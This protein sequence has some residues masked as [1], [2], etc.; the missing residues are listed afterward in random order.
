MLHQTNKSRIERCTI[1]A[2][3]LSLVAMSA[4]SFAAMSAF[5]PQ[6]KAGT[7][8]IRY[9]GTN[10]TGE[11]ISWRTTRNRTSPSNDTPETREGKT[12][13]Y[14]P[15]GS[16]APSGA[17]MRG[18][19]QQID[20]Y[21]KATYSGGYPPQ[22]TY[23]AGNGTVFAKANL[24]RRFEWRPYYSGE[25][26]PEYLTVRFN[27]SGAIY[28]D[29]N[30]KQ[31]INFLS[32]SMSLTG[33]LGSSPP[34]DLITGNMLDEGLG[35]PVYT[36]SVSFRKFDNWRGGHHYRYEISPKF[37]TQYSLIDNSTPSGFERGWR[38]ATRSDGTIDT[39]YD[40]LQRLTD[41]LW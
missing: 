7:W 5:A 22:I 17:G 19:S 29:T 41:S 28:L 12:G 25:P 40:L 20:I 16:P 32:G 10:G 24:I 31:N 27:A 39:W 3:Q 35:A 18:T 9:D 11:S 33:M 6:A 15:Q 14:G 8:T 13:L 4:L 30:Q 2:Q 23:S 37:T 26:L 34:E 1:A 36:P 38:Q 21:R